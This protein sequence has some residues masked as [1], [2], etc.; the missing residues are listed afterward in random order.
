M[1]L[2]IIVKIS[3]SLLVMQGRSGTKKSTGKFRRPPALI[4]GRN[5]I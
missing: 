3:I 4:A 1:M 2:V 5:L